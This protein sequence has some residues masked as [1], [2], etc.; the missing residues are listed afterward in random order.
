MSRWDNYSDDRKKELNKVS[1]DYVKNHYDRIHFNVP[2]GTRQRWL[3]EAKN[4]GFSGLAPFI[5]WCVEN[6]INFSDSS[7]N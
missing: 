3:E 5:K 6:C 7:D 2:A 1:S 4:R